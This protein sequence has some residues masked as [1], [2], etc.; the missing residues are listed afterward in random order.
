MWNPN[1]ETDIAGYKLL[2]GTQ[3]GT[4]SATI[5]VGNV[6]TWT[7]TTLASGTRYFFAVRAYNAANLLS[8]LSSEVFFDTPGSGPPTL[9]ALSPNTGGVGSSVTLTGFNF[10][11]TQGTSTVT[12]NG[13]VATP[14]SWSPSSIALS[15]PNGATTGNVVVTAGAASNGMMFTVTAA[16]A[17]SITGLSPSS[18]PVGSTVT[19][20]GANFGTTQ[21]TSTVKFNG[22]TAT[23][24]AWSSTSVAVTV[25]AG[26]TS[27]SVV[28]TVNNVASNASPY[29]V[30]LST[31]PAPWQT[32]DVGN[33]AVAGQASA[34]SGIFTVSGAGADIWD[35]SDQFRF[36]YQTFDGDGQIVARVD[37]LQNVDP[38]SK[39][40]VM[41]R[42]DLTAG[43]AN[44]MSEASAANGTVFQ[45]RVTA[46]GLTTS[47]KTLT[48]AVP[49]WVRLVRTGN[50][51][52]GYYSADGT[53]WTLISSSSVTL[54]THVYVGLVVLSHNAA[55][56][57][58]AT[59]SNVTVTS[60]TVAPSPSITSLSPATGVIGTSV[61]ITGTAFGSTQGTS[62]V[63][64][65]GTTATP[66]SWS[67]T[68]IVAPVP[69]GAS[70]GNV[71][72]T[73][74]NVS[75]NG[76]TFTVNRPPALTAVG[77]QSSLTSTAVSLQLT[78]TDP[79]GNA[80]TYGASGLPASL[81]VNPS[82]GLISGMLSS[83]SVGSYTVVATVSDGSLSDSK[84]FTWN[85]AQNPRVNVAAAA[86][87]GAATASSTYSAAYPASGAINGD[88]KGLNW[89][90]G[91][92]WADGTPGQ[93]PDWLEVDFAGAQTI[94]EIDV[95]SL[96][97]NAAAP[98]E[99]TL[100]MPFTLYGLTDFQVQ[101]W[102]G[103]QWVT[104]PGG[105]VTG[106]TQVWR[107]VL[108]TPLSTSRIR[109]L[110][111]G[112]L[113]NFSRIAE[114]EAYTSAAAQAQ[115]PA[116]FV[117]T[118]PINAAAP[119]SGTVTLAWQASS[120]AT[121]YEYCVDTTNNN[122]CDGSWVS[123]GT[124]TTAS[125]PATASTS[126][127]WQVRA[128]NVTG[129]TDATGG[130]W[131]F[132]AT[133]QTQVPGAFAK[134]SPV[135]AATPTSGTVTLAWQTSSGATSY[136]YCVDATNNNAC[137]GSWVSVGTQ[138]TANVSAAANTTS[139]W[140]VR[141]R[142][143]TGTTDATGGWWTFTTTQTQS[144]VN[145]AAA[146]NGGTAIASSAYSS[147]YAA[148][149][150]IDG[151]H[152]GLNWGA[153]GV[154]A[155]S[156][157]GQFPDWLEV[158]FAASQTIDEIDVFSLQDNVGAPVEPT[159]GMPFTVYGLTDFQV[160][161][162]NGTQWVT[163]PSGNVTGNT[164]V[165]RQL[166]L[167]PLTTSRI[168]VLVTGALGNF[169]R[170]VEVEAYTAGAVQT[171]LPAAF[172]KTSPTNAAAP[173]SGTVM[174]TW[175]ASSGA[176]SYEYCLD[177][178][179]NSACDGSWVSVGGQTT[180]SVPMAPNV[181]WWQV[182]ARNSVGTTDS[183]GGW[184][185]FTATT[186]TQSR[187]NVAAAANGGTA[188][189][190]SAYSS[191]YPASGAIDGDHKGLNWGAGGVWA[192]GTPGQSPDWLEV[193]FTG[194]QTINEID[195]FSLQDNVGSPVE[196]TLGMPFTVYGLTDFQV[197]S[198]NGTQWVTVPG[199]NVT[200]NTQVW[201]QVLFAP[202]TTSRIRVLVTGALANFSR[203]VEIEVYTP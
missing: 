181:Y 17:P 191:A 71:V 190:S 64:F 138:T 170:I 194:T 65:N 142:N 155:D 84:S 63:K 82:T 53:A 68:S 143:A 34:A 184:W 75:S 146:A 159:L 203:I 103:T 154:W 157:P 35:V 83:T 15:V 24:T 20:S 147:A 112:A 8:P 91:G 7:L 12:F 56:A 54:P 161:S 94:N 148:S 37:S 86:N 176:T 72:V 200:G 10:G 129:T 188:I 51:L 95:F 171:Q 109:V 149:G 28:V 106:N 45:S 77:N 90:A 3:S 120:G 160:Q 14:T 70:T 48:G 195:V 168:R 145:V 31:L 93:F 189:T 198:W 134:T 150:A 114:V 193:D 121:S 44:A 27:G 22:T 89:G 124:Q 69:S 130:W 177:T 41:I 167:A 49:Q 117:K 174:L 162:W 192:D 73:V 104:V 13:T 105:S 169:S 201:R 92:A 100:G 133:A 30:T 107:Q 9:T 11:S 5:D 59:F 87:G 46:G 6:T 25:P 111:T 119:A 183:T 39:A 19:I 186:Q 163:V 178:T 113:G 199:G 158:D 80:L 99:P 43:A 2:Y 47:V 185:T 135:N 153:G 42:G 101:S 36:V 173:A 62:T 52:T 140:Q 1:P 118:S 4:Y 33:P 79:D 74:A 165:W 81:G 26:A 96:Q 32:Q 67:A 156:T 172:A 139:W 110:V 197:Q 151:D 132:T 175:Q 128:R 97:D 136:E 76:R 179:N 116:T 61:T 108:F 66:T 131:T 60:G 127:W 98:V 50:T 55:T 182:R 88:H 144:R 58:T 18:G 166:L 78:A 102:D 126:Y 123:V 57:A 23:S 21:G 152:K 180:A 29:T 196:P 137:D 202:L 16:P 115:P 164:Q 85:V 122:A 125:V 38:W 141:A 187:V 40:G